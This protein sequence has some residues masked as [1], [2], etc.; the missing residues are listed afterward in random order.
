MTEKDRYLTH[1]GY[2][3]GTPEAEQAWVDKCAMMARMDSGETQGYYI[4]SEEKLYKPYKSMQTGEIIEGRAKHRKHLKEHG[5]VEVGN[6]PV[7]KAKDRYDGNGIKQE[8]I[9]QLYSK[10]R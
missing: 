4:A 6:E 2:T 1:W 3:L 5:L 8:L 10:G 7:R 9:R